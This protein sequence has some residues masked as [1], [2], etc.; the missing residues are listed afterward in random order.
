MKILSWQKT[1]AMYEASEWRVI[2]H[3][4]DEITIYADSKG[5]E[6][7]FYTFEQLVVGSPPTLR[8]VAKIPAKAVRHYETSY[9][10]RATPETP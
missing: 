1:L 2:L 10:G 9:V 5:E 3:S 4:G 6:D 7:G 8:R